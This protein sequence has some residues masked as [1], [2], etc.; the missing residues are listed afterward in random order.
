MKILRSNTSWAILY[1]G[2][3]Y[4]LI[5]QICT[6]YCSKQNMCVS[7]SPKEY[8]YTGG[9]SPG[10]EILLINYPR[11]PSSASVILEHAEK[12]GKQLLFKCN[13]K[14]YSCVMPDITYTYIR[15]SN[16]VICE[17]IMQISKLNF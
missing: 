5:K 8:I 1:I 17:E 14:S 4:N 9:Y 12:L 7:L 15:E 6:D 13:Q 11:F 10:A 2:G 16:D 3:D